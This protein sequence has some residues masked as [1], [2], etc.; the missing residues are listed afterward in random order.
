MNNWKPNY[1]DSNELKLNALICSLDENP[2][3]KLNPVEG[4]KYLNFSLAV[5]EEGF[6]QQVEK[7]L[8]DF[9]EYLDVFA[10]RCID[11]GAV[12]TVLL[13]TISRILTKYR[14]AQYTF[15]YSPLRLEWKNFSRNF[16]VP[17]SSNDFNLAKEQKY[18]RQAYR[19]FYLC[20][21]IQLAFI[22]RVID[23]LTTMLNSNGVKTND[24]YPAKQK[25][26]KEQT[27]KE[28]KMLH[29]TIQ[30][31]AK[32]RSHDILQYIHKELKDAGY[33]DCNLPSFKRVFMSEEPSPIIWLKPYNHLSYFIKSLG[34]KFIDNPYS[35]SNMEVARKYIYNKKYGVYFT[36]K[37]R[38]DKNPAKS[39]KEFFDGIILNSVDHFIME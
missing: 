20:S 31:V 24:S 18:T 22:E 14:Q 35:Q 7:V 33:I 23:D 32:S 17:N 28:K 13:P 16:V 9:T 11:Q 25:I 27:P 4:T 37:V 10:K 39:V 21:S 5:S 2:Q 6:Q 15:T 38:H 36:G 8:Q 19:F 26:S 3:L 34:G 29:F 30:P 12:N 1:N